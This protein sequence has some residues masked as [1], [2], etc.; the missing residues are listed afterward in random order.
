[1]SRQPGVVRGT[2]WALAAVLATSAL[3]ACSGTNSGAPTAPPGA[4]SA[5]S[6][7][8][9]ASEAPTATAWDPPAG[10]IEPNTL[11]GYQ[12][13]TQLADGSWSR[14]QVDGGTI[15][16]RHTN[17]A[18][19]TL[20][21]VPTVPGL[22][23]GTP[24]SYSEVPGVLTFRGGPQ[25]GNAGFGD[26]E[27]KQGRL[28]LRWTAPLGRL[29]SFGETWPGAGWT[30]Q[31]LLV[32]WPEETRKAMGLSEDFAK[33]GGVEV[34]YPAFDGRIHRLDLATGAQTKPPIEVGYGFKGT[35]SVDPRGFPLLYAGQ[36]LPDNSGRRGPWQFRIFDLITNTQTAMIAGSDPSAYR[37]A[38][39]AFDSSALV[40]AGTDTLLEPGENGVYYRVRL[41]SQFDAPARSVS[42]APEVTRLVFESGRSSRFGMENSQ[43][44]YRN[45]IYVSDN[46]GNLNCLDARTLE[47]VWSRSIGDD[48]DATMAIE[49][50]PTGVYLYSANEVDHRGFHQQVSNIRKIDA[51]TGKVVWRYD[52][53]V[54]FDESVNGGVLG[55][56]LVSEREDVRDRVIVNVARTRSGLGGTLMALDKSTGAPLWSRPLDPYSW[57]S[58][59]YVPAS[60]GKTYGVFADQAGTIHLF[61][62]RTGEDV[63]TFATGA[64]IEASP[65][66]F[67]STI[68]VASRDQK[69]YAL[70]IS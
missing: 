14:P 39:G 40:H 5:P 54:E 24:A 16:W 25:R 36:G 13:P 37:R 21:A 9:S 68:V 20:R 49:E 65:A 7:T 61:D 23:F 27:V 48:A 19:D 55:S 38:W 2:R 4:S 35:G 30:G 10:A 22:V 53:G 34:L 17:A 42:V 41:R 47:I 56:L 59:L 69:V 15:R 64:N 50:T 44:A 57:T 52:V 67:G 46:D 51:L 29:R 62:P 26:A 70:T 45:L 60:S 8:P 43:V 31:P 66:A 28:S 32:K 33:D 18:G 3:T 12:K 6:T 11:P 63:D 1:M 58:V